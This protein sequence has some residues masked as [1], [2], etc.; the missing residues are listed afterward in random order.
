MAELTHIK[1]VE[2]KNLWD[3]YDLK[4]KLDKDVNILSGINGSGKSTILDVIACICRNTFQPS[5]YKYLIDICTVRFNNNVFTGYEIEYSQK[6]ND[7]DLNIEIQTMSATL[8]QNTTY[9]K[10]HKA[11][12]FDIINTFDQPFLNKYNTEEDPRKK[13]AIYGSNLDWELFELHEYYLNYQV[14]LGKKIE[15][16]YKAGFKNPDNTISTIYE[17]VTLFKKTINEMFAET[18]KRINDDDN[19]ISFLTW[20]DEPLYPGQLSSGEKQLLIILMKA[21]VQDNKPAVMIMDEPEISLHVDWQ[22]SLISRI[23]ALNPNVQ[24][25]IATH[26]PAMI[27]EGWAD[28]VVEVRDIIVKDRKIDNE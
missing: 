7:N 8:K 12:L 21:L 24:L 13:E 16:A 3:R 23:K 20:Q 17:N 18:G 25:I 9:D 2:I 6:E 10:I 27:I 22:K 11:L 15:Q 19:K 14:V 26:S 28:K 1:E 5:L 4:W